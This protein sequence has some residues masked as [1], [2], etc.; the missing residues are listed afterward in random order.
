MM[1]LNIF[2]WH[3]TAFLALYGAL[4]AIA[5]VASLWIERASRPEGRSANIAGDDIDAL[6]WLT[7]GTIR[8][9]DA[10][11]T[12]LLASGALKVAE[13][14]KLAVVRP[15]G[16]NSVAEQRIL[17]LSSPFTYATAV[18][19]IA[20]DAEPVIARLQRNGLLLDA[21]ELM[22]L[23][24]L[25]ALPLIAL[26]GIGGIKLALGLGRDRPVGF[27]AVFL[28][29]TLITI[30]IRWSTID[31]RTGAARST[32]R[33][34]QGR[35]ERLKR[36]TTQDEAALGVALFGTVVL[37]GS[38]LDGFHRMRGSDGGSGGDSSSSDGGCGG[39]GCGGCGGG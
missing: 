21:G 9:V 8:F 22:R 10:L 36:A 14:N 12:R 38:G 19:Q 37:A 16:G 28:I 18:R 1:S 15:D 6:A 39:G 32:I 24:W 17:N 35:Q 2:D 11:L 13:R 31:R 26:S 29:F 4:F 7:G 23:R 34:Q 3:G 30:A 5:L 33:Q 27:L 25:A 20:A